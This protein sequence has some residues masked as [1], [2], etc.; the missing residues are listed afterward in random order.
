MR[1]W[2]AALTLTACLLWRLPALASLGP[3][4]GWQQESNV[5]GALHGRSV[6]TAGD[7]NGDGFSDA[8]VGAYGYSNGQANESAAFLYLGGGGPLPLRAVWGWCDAKRN[9]S[10]EA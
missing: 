8:I 10:W 6:A 4:P 2:V 5:C 9:E 1:R 3:S 7:V